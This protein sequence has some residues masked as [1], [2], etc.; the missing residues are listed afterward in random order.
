MYEW[1]SLLSR[2]VVASVSAALNLRVQNTLFSSEGAF[3][4][5][6]EAAITP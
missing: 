1:D 2:G 5:L 6:K 3:A 4:G